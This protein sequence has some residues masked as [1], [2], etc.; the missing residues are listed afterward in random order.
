[1][2]RSGALVRGVVG[3]SE[4]IILGFSDSSGRS[5]STP[6][7][8]DA[9]A[10][11]TARQVLVEQLVVANLVGRDVSADLLEHRFPYRVAQRC[12]IGTRPDFDDAARDHLS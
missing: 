3:V 12:V 7:E 1:M 9:L 10:L 2:I 4:L 5:P 6:P 11:E 8:S